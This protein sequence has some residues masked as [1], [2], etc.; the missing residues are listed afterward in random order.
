[1]NKKGYK[2]IE[3]KIKLDQLTIYLVNYYEIDFFFF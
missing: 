1:M 2:N 3:L